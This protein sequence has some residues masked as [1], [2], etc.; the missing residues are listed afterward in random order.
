M[1]DY[2]AL[3]GIKQMPD[4]LAKYNP[5]MK[6]RNT[7]AQIAIFAVDHDEKLRV[8]A[9]QNNATQGTVLLVIQRSCFH[10]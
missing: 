6:M 3:E 9:I 10:G 2:S 1:V 8:I 7:P 5:S 4:I